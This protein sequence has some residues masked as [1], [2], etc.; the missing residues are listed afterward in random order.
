MMKNRIFL[1]LCLIFFSTKTLAELEDIAFGLGNLTQFVKKVQVDETGS[2]NS[3]DFN[4]YLT[5]NLKI[6]LYADFSFLPETILVRPTAGTDE[7][8]T[9]FTF[10]VTLPFGYTFSNW[11]FRLG[12]GFSMTRISSEGGEQVLDNGLEMTSFPLPQESALSRNLTLHAGIE[13]LFVKR[14]SVRTELITYNLTQSI[15]RAFSYTISV[16]YH[17]GKIE[18]NWW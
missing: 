6:R 8:I 7:N 15:S 13:Y 3:L 1:A 9:R 2:T 14:V 11:V 16:H 18:L 5:A 4:P 17:T 10:F 12:P